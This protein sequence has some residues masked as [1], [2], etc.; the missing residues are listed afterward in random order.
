MSIV[1]IGYMASGKSLIGKK[2]AKELE[3]A[4]YDLDTFIEKQEG[5]KISE[6]FSKRGEVYFRKIE[7]IF[8]K[9]LLK[10]KKMLLSP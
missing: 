5:M 1:L 9:Q 3:C 7:S 10:N 4:F 8:L 6:I 2:L